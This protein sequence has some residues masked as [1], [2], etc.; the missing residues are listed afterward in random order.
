MSNEDTKRPM[1]LPLPMSISS[2]EQ[3]AVEKE[4]FNIRFAV[5]R[6]IC[7]ELHFNSLVKTVCNFLLHESSEKLQ[8]C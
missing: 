2:P 5:C 6:S 3:G 7:L 4:R 8:S 1:Q